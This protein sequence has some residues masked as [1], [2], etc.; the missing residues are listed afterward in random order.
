MKT[1]FLALLASTVLAQETEGT[2]S[3]P[4]GPLQDSDT[5]CPPGAPQEPT[6][7]PDI[8]TA[9]SLGS[10]ASRDSAIVIGNEDYAWLSD[11]SHAIDDANAFR[12]LL[13]KTVGV[14]TWRMRF[15][16]EANRREMRRGLKRAVSRVRRKGTLWVYFSGHGLDTGLDNGPALLGE[17][18]DNS[19]ESARTGLLFLQEALELLA[20][21]RAERVVVIIDASF[22]GRGRN[23][24]PLFQP[25]TDIGNDAE[26]GPIRLSNECPRNDAAETTAS[27]EQQADCQQQEPAREDPFTLRV[28]GNLALWT[29]TRGSEDAEI[30]AD[31]GLF[32]Y[33]VVAAM[34]GWADGYP[35]NEPDGMVTLGEAQDYVSSAMSRLG[36]LQLP[37][38]H[39]PGSKK[40]WV[41]TKGEL[42]AAPPDQLFRQL[43]LQYLDQM[44]RQQEEQLLENA[45]ASWERAFSAASEGNDDG[46]LALED[47]IEDNEHLVV[48]V[49]WAIHSPLLDQARQLLSTYGEWQ[50]QQKPGSDG[51]PAGGSQPE[52]TSEPGRYDSGGDTGQQPTPPQ[53]NSCDDLERLETQAMEGTLRE[54][55]TACLQERFS[56]TRKITT[57]DKISR[58]LLVN[59]EGSG[60]K[61]LWESLLKRHLSEID[62]SD[63]DMCFK[64][65][66]FLSRR[67][68]S[69]ADEVIKWAGR[70][71][72]NK[73]EWTGAE[74]AKK[75]YLLHRLRAEAASELWTEA[76]ERYLSER[77]LQA[78]QRAETLRG[79]AKELTKAWLDYARASGQDDS[80]ALAL[81]LAAA[82]TMEFC[83]E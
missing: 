78:E 11:A 83:A 12:D 34:R 64:Y 14:P 59:A 4:V 72:E 22:N 29:A 5:R 2:D 68:L 9:L 54:A 23:G 76:E 75:V 56:S 50:E 3:T 66:V 46:R 40:N 82:G 13:L 71:L 79:N 1:L 77:T 47:F 21:S 20:K 43:S 61:Q 30:F 49:E 81:C 69:R 35:G 63:P 57:K 17:D 42:E 70:A 41:L 62:Q 15:L 58:L 24:E 36:R 16:T 44:L 53:D 38:N 8:S 28:P 45:V 7:P 10:K 18:Y 37:S 32:T 51:T 39:D 33:L 25:G 31:H 27:T 48:N 74:H 26:A 52:E 73:D 65:S 19:Q 55:Q 80:S 6:A 60:N 67:G